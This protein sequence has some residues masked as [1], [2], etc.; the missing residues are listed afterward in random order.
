[1]RHERINMIPF[2][3][4][5]A[6]MED[7]QDLLAIYAPY[8]RN[9]TIT[10][11]YDVPSCEEF[12]ERMGHI[13]EGYPYLVCESGGH[14]MGYAYAHR[15][16]ERAAYQWDAELSVYV[17]EAYTGQGIGRALYTALM[18]ILKLQHVKTVYGLVTSP[19]PSSEALHRA[20][21]FRLSGISERTGYKLGKW[22][23]VACFEKPVGSR[24]GEPE[25]LLSFSQV[26]KEE[27]ERILKEAEERMSDR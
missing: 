15:Y 17:E 19:N 9:T 5:E 26:N 8:I 7:A 10:F 24:E 22:V 27:V 3:L 16:H 18:E 14:P 2:S 21:G 23:D 25:P 13:M 20:L 12:R 4:R 11:E 6:C 1:M